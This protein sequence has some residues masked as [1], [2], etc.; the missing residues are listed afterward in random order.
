MKRVKILA[1][2]L[3]LLLALMP[4]PGK[5]ADVSPGVYVEEL[6]VGLPSITPVVTAVAVQIHNQYEI[7]VYNHQTNGIM[8]ES[9][10]N[11]RR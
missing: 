5:A 4:Y 8:K 10:N 6:P 7:P 11:E 9:R 1:I 2:T 3:L